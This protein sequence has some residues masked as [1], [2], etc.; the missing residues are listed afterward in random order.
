MQPFASSMIASSGQAASEQLLMRSPSTPTSPNSLMMNA[1]RRPPAL[2]IR[3]RISVVLPAPRK[4]VTMVTGVLA[5]MRPILKRCR[6]S[7]GERRRARHDTL[8]K[9]ERPLAPRNDAL[10]RGRIAPRGNDDVLEVRLAVKISDDVSPFARRGE[11][12]RA[13]A[14]ANGEAFD[15]FKRNIGLRRET[16]AE[17]LEHPRPHRAGLGFAGDADQ[18]RRGGGRAA[19]GVHSATV[20]VGSN[21]LGANLE[22]CRAVMNAPRP[23]LRR[24][25]RTYRARQVSWLT[26]YRRRRL[27]RLMKKSSGEKSVGTPLTVAGAATDRRQSLPCSLF[28]LGRNRGTVRCHVPAS[29]GVVKWSANRFRAQRSR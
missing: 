29:G 24:P 23:P 8:A 21:E 16:F 22:I 18:Q 5:S 14:L 13:R 10:G 12:D 25:Y 9:A 27:P 11:R 26:A 17:R 3:W 2:A 19:V 4:P 7:E 20:P 1:S 28:T 15:G 6:F